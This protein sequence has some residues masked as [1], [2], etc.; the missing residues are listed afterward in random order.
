MTATAAALTYGWLVDGA[1]WGGAIF[2]LIAWLLLGLG[3]PAAVCTLFWFFNGL[4]SRINR[5]QS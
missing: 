4:F 2:G 1:D 5:S 3:I